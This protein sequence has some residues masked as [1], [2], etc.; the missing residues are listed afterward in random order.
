MRND[1]PASIV[2]DLAAGV[3]TLAAAWVLRPK[4]GEPI[5]FTD[6]DRDLM[7]EGVLC[8]ALAGFDGGEI[9][10]AIGA[11]IDQ[12][13]FT[14]AFDDRTLTGA[15]LAS[16][17]FD[18]ADALFYRIDWRVPEHFILLWRGRL[19]AIRRGAH[20][21]EAELVSL[22][23]GLEHVV[24][25]VYR[26]DCGAQLGDARCRV[27]VA[28]PR[29]RMAG[30]VIAVPAAGEIEV[31]GLAEFAP[32]WFAG[33]TLIWETGANAGQSLFIRAERRKPDTALL[34][35]SEN[36]AG[37]IAIGD[38]FILTAGCDKRFETCRTKF[39]NTPNFQGFPHMPGEDALI[40]GPGF[41]PRRDGRSRFR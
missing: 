13:G 40:A 25:R 28:D 26:R 10:N 23:T 17:R 9:E 31:S 24:G 12:A 22:K 7:I 14:A 27:D 35:F 16:G 32:G 29:F 39:A 19:G 15:D 36:A 5:G 8:H 3:S 37:R 41:D 30:E 33:G 34:T 18:G 21:F 6:H 20:A 2:A 38:R 11:R 4:S 1:V